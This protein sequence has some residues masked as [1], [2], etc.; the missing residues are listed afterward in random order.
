MPI[1]NWKYVRYSRH[2]MMKQVLDT[3]KKALVSLK[4]KGTTP[5][6]LEQQVA[7]VQKPTDGHNH[8]LLSKF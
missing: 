7:S 4:T 2:N 6:S 3:I 1:I 8:F 5:T